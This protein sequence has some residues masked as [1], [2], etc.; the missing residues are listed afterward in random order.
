M[1][2]T[3]SLFSRW[4]WLKWICFVLLFSV[5][6]S[7]IAG[8]GQKLVEVSQEKIPSEMRDVMLA[9]F[10]DHQDEYKDLKWTGYEE[11]DGYVFAACEFTGILYFMDET[12]R[13]PMFTTCIA[14]PAEDGTFEVLHMSMESKPR[15]DNLIDVSWQSS[16]PPSATGQCTDKRIHKVVGITVRGLQ[17]EASRGANGWWFLIAE[18]A[19]PDD[20]FEWIG[21]VNKEGKAILTFFGETMPTFQKGQ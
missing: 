10:D 17:L 11:R 2:K 4:R 16:R 1:T 20:R 8:C 6:L 15:T 5:A 18:D 3:R 12:I 19:R 9:W 14:E 7:L 13:R 21:G